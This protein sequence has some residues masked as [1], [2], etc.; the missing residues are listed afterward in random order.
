[1]KK[2]TKI[3]GSLSI[4][5]LSLLTIFGGLGFYQSKSIEKKLISWNENQQKELKKLSPNLSSKI[6]VN[7]GFLKTKV[8][9]IID[10]NKENDFLIKGKSHTN[11]VIKHNFLNLLNPTYNF[12]AFTKESL[13]K[14]IIVENDFFIKTDVVISKNNIDKNK[15]DFKMTFNFS[16]FIIEEIHDKTKIK[17]SFQKPVLIYVKNSKDNKNSEH[18]LKFNLAEQSTTIIAPLNTKKSSI[19]NNF[20][21]YTDIKNNSI[22]SNYKINIKNISV[23]AFD[24][25]N[26]QINSNVQEN[27]NHY[28]FINLLKID[29]ISA[30]KLTDSSLNLQFGVKSM[31]KEILDLINFEKLSKLSDSELSEEYKNISLNL[32]KKGISLGIDKFEI[33][34]DKGLLLANFSLD[35]FENNKVSFEDNTKIKLNI[36]T[37]GVFTSLIDLLFFNISNAQ[38]LKNNNGEFLVVYDRNNLKINNFNISDTII[39]KTLRSFLRKID[40]ELGVN[41]TDKEELF[42]NQ[43]KILNK[44]SDKQKNTDIIFKEQVTYIP[45]YMVLAKIN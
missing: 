25:T 11:F 13:I 42:K 41:I 38:L 21:F 3:L 9:F 24:L 10:N 39:N 27:D 32:I 28:D 16:D 26:L 36:K 18:F 5:S 43:N 17:N 20:N 35:F 1:M 7:K 22:L 15:T 31:N 12:T 30:P 29:N 34:S 23:G 8:N 40:F 44:K 45:K 2:T 33:N 37:T 4:L 14:N 19:I 6:E